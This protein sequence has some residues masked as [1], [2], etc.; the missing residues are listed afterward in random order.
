MPLPPEFEALG[1][2]PER[3]AA[4][5]IVRIRSHGLVSNLADQVD[6]RARA[7][8]P[9]PQ[10]GARCACGSSRSGKLEIPD[11]LDLADIPDDVLDVYDLAIAPVKFGDGRGRRAGRQARAR[12][13]GRSPAAARRAGRPILAND[14]HRTQGVPSLRYMAHLNAPGLNVIGAGEPALPGISIGHNER[15]AFGLTIFAIDQ[16]DLYVYETRDGQ[17][18]TSTATATASRR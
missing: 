1:Y 12:T 4:E 10:G 7:A 14:P 8:R 6:A 3:W 11:G 18:R 15:I 13:T 9:R 17:R 16:E 5:D 2:A